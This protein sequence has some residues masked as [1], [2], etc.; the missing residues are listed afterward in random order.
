VFLTLTGTPIDDDTEP[1]ISTTTVPTI[2]TADEQ[3]AARAA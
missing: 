1:D 2:P 3:L